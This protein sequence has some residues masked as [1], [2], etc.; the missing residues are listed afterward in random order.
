[1]LLPISVLNHLIDLIV[2]CSDV[3]YNVFAPFLSLSP[4]EIKLLKQGE[5]YVIS[6]VFSFPYL[7]L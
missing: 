2:E 1:M 3:L 7:A 5:R 4:P 6:F